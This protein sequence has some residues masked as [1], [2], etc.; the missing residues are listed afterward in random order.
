MIFIS[1][2]HV[3]FHLCLLCLQKDPVVGK[4]TDTVSK[5]NLVDLAG[6]ERLDS[7]GA[8]GETLKV[9][10]VFQLKLTIE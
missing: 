5:I 6:S 8:S 9:I 10:Q 3:W 1:N 2:Y 7:T 4:A